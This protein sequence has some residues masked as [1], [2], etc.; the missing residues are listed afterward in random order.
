MRNEKRRYTI[1]V[2]KKKK[3][4][5][6]KKTRLKKKSFVKKVIDNVLSSDVIFDEFFSCFACLFVSW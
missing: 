6:W 2:E 4:G 3:A 5:K 1:K